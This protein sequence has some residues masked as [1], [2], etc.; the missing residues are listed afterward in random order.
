MHNLKPSPDP[1]LRAAEL[2][3]AKRPLVVE[4]SD[5]GIESARSAGF[6]SLR[7][8][9]ADMVAREVR[10]RLGDVSGNN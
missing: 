6:D 10:M 1:Y 9:S 4:D 5:A 3:G 8:S 2:L 7:V